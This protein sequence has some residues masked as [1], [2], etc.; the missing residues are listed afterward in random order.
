MDCPNCTTTFVFRANYATHVQQCRP[1]AATDAL[2]ERLNAEAARLHSE[3]DD[4][5]PKRLVTRRL[6]SAA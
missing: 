6:H 4:V 1:D 2:L 5:E 3:F